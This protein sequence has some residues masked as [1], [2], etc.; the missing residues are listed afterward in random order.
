MRETEEV[1]L[2]AYIS[3][4]I[5]FSGLGGRFMIF[6]VR[7]NSTPIRVY[8]IRG[9]KDTVALDLYRDFKGKPI[10]TLVTVTVP[11]HVISE[12]DS[13]YFVLFEKDTFKVSSF[14]LDFLVLINDFMSDMYCSLHQPL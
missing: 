6:K 1:T 14:L 8:S 7:V 5:S 13:T 2:N 4:V 11:S 10:S 9:N 12:Y 3:H